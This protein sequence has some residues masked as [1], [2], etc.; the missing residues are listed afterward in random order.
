M[1]RFVANF[2]QSGSRMSVR[3]PLPSRMTRPVLKHGLL[4]V[5]LTRHLTRSCNT[6]AAAQ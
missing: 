2:T 5:V 1:Q 3:M 4:E 6:T